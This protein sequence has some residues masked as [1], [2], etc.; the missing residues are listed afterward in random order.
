MKSLHCRALRTVT[1][2]LLSLLL[3]VA[4]P[5]ADDEPVLDPVVRD[6]VRMLEEGVDPSLVL[7]WLET[8]ERR[9]GPLGP[10]DLIALSRAGAS[11]Q[12]TRRL[13]DVAAQ[14]PPAERTPVECCLVDFE[15]SYRAAEPMEGEQEAPGKDLAV[16][17]DGQPLVRLES[18]PHLGGGG[19]F[20]R[21]LRLDPGPHTLRLLRERHTLKKSR[22]LHDSRVSPDVIPFEI[23]P[24]ASFSLE[25]S[26]K[27]SPFSTSGP[28]DWQLSRD[29]VTI[30]AQRDTGVAKEDWPPLC[31]D[32][33]VEGCVRWQDLWP[34]ETTIP[35][36][37]EV[38]AELEAAGYRPFND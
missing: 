22:W 20:E 25:V 11:E 21:R 13:I 12:L 6:V 4:A 38:R 26:W 10:E 30:A 33:P 9:P 19:P 29:G 14:P 3:T 28:L 23:E 37:E 34:P 36:R 32:G 15:I 8:S 5:L 24:G 16:Y 35:S 7:H 27:E 17:L 2:I 31:D 18:M 1:L